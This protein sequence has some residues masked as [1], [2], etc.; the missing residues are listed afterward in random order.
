MLPDFI[1]FQFA[2]FEAFWDED[3]NANYFINGPR[4]MEVAD[5]E[6]Q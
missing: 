1:S 6:N 5:E 4:I 2:C 3:V